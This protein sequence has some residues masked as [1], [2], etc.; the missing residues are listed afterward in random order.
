MIKIM[1][2]NFVS[3]MKCKQRSISLSVGAIVDMK[4]STRNEH[5]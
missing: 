4:R 5:Q 1:Q 2:G 3:A